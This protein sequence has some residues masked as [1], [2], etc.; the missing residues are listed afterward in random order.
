MN[1]Q[2]ILPVYV[3]NRPSVLVNCGLLILLSSSRFFLNVSKKNDNNCFLFYMIASFVPSMLRFNRG[4]TTTMTNRPT[5]TPVLI[6]IIKFNQR[7]IRWKY[8]TEKQK[9][10]DRIIE[11]SRKINSTW[12]SWMNDWEHIDH[13]RCTIE[14]WQ[15][16]KTNIH[17]ILLKK[18]NERFL[19]LGDQRK[20][21]LVQEL[22]FEWW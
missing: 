14:Y 16:T 2:D 6:V 5:R 13:N 17:M 12:W 1:N 19:F 20:E 10:N 8:K 4:L 21:L 22:I 15:P 9:H 11:N 7:G 3:S 18:S